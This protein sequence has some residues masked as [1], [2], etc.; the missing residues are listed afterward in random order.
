MPGVLQA[1]PLLTGCCRTTTWEAS[2]LKRCGSCRACSLCESQPSPPPAVPPLC[3]PLS[4]PRSRQ[5]LASVSSGFC[6]RQSVY[7]HTHVLSGKQASAPPRTVGIGPPWV[8]PPGQWSWG[9][10]LYYGAWGGGGGDCHPKKCQEGLSPPHRLL[11]PPGFWG[12][13]H[14]PCCWGWGSCV[15]DSLATR[16]TAVLQGALHFLCCP[17]GAWW[18]QDRAEGGSCLGLQCG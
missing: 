3:A 7:M 5:L 2:P 18:T 10:W 14:F 11:W 12:V 15:W 6:C 16:D 1:P 8:G 9:V 4:P 17:L 13:G